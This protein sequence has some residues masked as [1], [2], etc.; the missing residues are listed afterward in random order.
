ME[1]VLVAKFGELWLRGR[2]RGSFIRILIKNIH[3]ALAG[4]SYKLENKYDR[5]VIHAD[6]S[7][8]ERI[9][10]KLKNV[11]G[12]SN[13][14]IA[15]ITE[16][17]LGKIER[18]AESFIAKMKAGGSKAIKINA[19]RSYKGL[20]FDSVKITK[21]V[22]EIIKEH[23][24][25]ATSKAYDSQI[26]INVSKDAAYLYT[27]VEECARGLPVGSSG[28]GII[29][30][31]GGIDSPVAAWYAMKRGLAPIYLHVHAFKS[32]EEINSTKVPKLLDM[33]AKYGR[34]KVYY[35]PGYFFQVAAMKASR[36]YEAV[37]FKAFLFRI[38]EKIAKK[39]GASAIITGESLGQVASQTVANIHASEL[40]IKM[41]I[42]RPL[43]GF[44]KEEIIA[45]ARRI[46][47]YEES[48]KPYKD[49]CSIGVRRPT[50]AAD[51]DA[52]KKMLKTIEISKIVSDS[53]KKAEVSELQK[54]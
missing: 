50:T 15:M 51:I 32:V 2:N 47:T 49:V 36:S 48:I 28:K 13:C 14:Y 9:K 26:F 37:L 1:E 33:L 6:A 34:A 53:L 54:V 45:A 3:S 40:G 31:S 44:D 27:G 43:I 11:F 17:E 8:L 29:L 38:A 35:I 5:L 41:P 10:G 46:G 16:P 12:L 4:E 25:D 21:N 7:S 23:G 24:I 52:V 30:F 19:H 39:E 20:P 18:L 42:L 22:A